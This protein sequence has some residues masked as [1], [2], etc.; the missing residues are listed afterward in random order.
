[1]LFLKGFRFKRDCSDTSPNFSVFP[2][3]AL[4]FLYRVYLY[5]FLDFSEDSGGDVDS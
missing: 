2:I 1:M 4:D 3:I 5:T